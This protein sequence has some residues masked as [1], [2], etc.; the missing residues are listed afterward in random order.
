MNPK[1]DEETR[2]NKFILLFTS[3][4]GCFAAAIWGLVYIWFDE[5][6]AGWIPLS[7]AIITL[8]S[9]IILRVFNIYRFFSFSQIFMSLVL[10]FLLMASLGGY[11]NGSAVIIWGLFAPISALLSGKLK[12]SQYW[13]AVYAALLIVGGI[14]QPYLRT[15][16]NIP[17]GV[18]TSF[19]VFNLGAV[20]FIIFEVLNFFVKKKDDVIGLMRKNRD[21]EQAYL[22]QE[23]MLRQS[24]KLATLGRLSAGM[25]HELNNPATVALR[26]SKQLLD[27]VQKSQ[28]AQYRLGQLQLSKEQRDIFD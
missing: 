22:Q 23:V 9:L 18:Q 4:A 21:L 11:I 6:L 8:F 26:G 28:K 27:N 17:S 15:S 7:Y 1:D 5:V 10:P 24:D 25:A 3:T 19:F 13:Y 14:L 20:T 2:I 12:Q 16:N